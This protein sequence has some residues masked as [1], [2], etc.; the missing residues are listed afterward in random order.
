M[1]TTAMK[2]TT[3]MKTAL[4]S[5][6]VCLALSA[7]AAD[8]AIS[9]VT[10]RQRWPWSRLVDIDYVLTCDATQ[11]VD[12]A[13]SAYDGSTALSFPLNALS[14]DLY[15][16]SPG[17]K[18]VVLDPVK[19]VYTNDLLTQFR[20]SLTPTNP[21]V[22]M[23]V[24]LTKSAGASN[25]I[26]YIYP[27]DAR[28]AT[29]GRWTNVWFGVTN[30]QVYAT[31]K[32]VLR[33]VQAGAFKMGE[34]V[35]PT[36]S[37]TLTRDFYAGVFEVTEAQWNKVMGSGS[38]SAKAKTGLSYNTIRG[39]TDSVP[40]VN[41]YTT[42]SSVSPTNFIGLLRAATGVATFDLPTEA[43]GEY[44]CR[45]GTASY[46]S[47]GQSGGDTDTNILS[48]LGWWVGNSGGAVH[49]A[50]QKEA[51]GWGL[52]DTHGNASEWCLD[53]YGGTLTGKTDP[54]GPV[55]GGGRVLRGG[56]YGDTAYYNRSASRYQTHPASAGW[57]IGLRLVLLLP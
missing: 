48:R 34:G 32:L 25:Q 39:A 16:V 19:T 54:V 51:N 33:R 12:V 29:E 22:Y 26:E 21:P 1:K 45:G 43:Q 35:P 30:D 42:G 41:W 37:T 38:I 56:N 44:L 2:M 23:I 7:V 47:D 11:R 52:Y 18:H 27:G 50:G 53:W 31:D 40:T 57:S 6:A 10:V 13:L 9:D 4:G 5:F 14:G 46:F 24:D 15:N 8:P 3:A 20:V 55:S 28:L 49:V 17:G 36:L